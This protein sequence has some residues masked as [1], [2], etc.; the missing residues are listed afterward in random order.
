MNRST[1]AASAARARAGPFGDATERLNRD[2]PAVEP[3]ARHGATFDHREG[4][5]DA[6]HR[7]Q[8]RMRAEDRLARP[9]AEEDGI[10]GAEQARGRHL[11]LRR[12]RRQVDQSIL[13][14]DQL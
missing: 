7:H 8:V 9:P 12:V 11:R 6:V 5:E 4:A 1:S 13:A 2:L 10:E 14:L 3:P